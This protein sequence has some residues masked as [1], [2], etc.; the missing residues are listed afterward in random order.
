MSN[1]FILKWQTLMRKP[2][3]ETIKW[4]FHDSAHVRAMVRAQR[5]FLSLSYWT[6]CSAAITGYNLSKH[7]DQCQNHTKDIIGFKTQ[8]SNLA[9]NIEVIIRPKDTFRIHHKLY[10]SIWLVYKNR[11]EWCMGVK[12]DKS[13]FHEKYHL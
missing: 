9:L 6:T 8:L 2:T 12:I 4:L 7:N 13:N 3:P 1:H 5:A 11:I 10:T